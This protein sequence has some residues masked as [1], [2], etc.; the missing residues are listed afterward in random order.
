MKILHITVHP[1]EIHITQLSKNVKKCERNFSA[2]P[3]FSPLFEMN[4]SNIAT[5]SPSGILAVQVRHETLMDRISVY[6]CEH[7]REFDDQSLA[8]FSIGPESNGLM[9]YPS[10]CQLFFLGTCNM[11]KSFGW[12]KLPFWNMEH[13]IVETFC[14]FGHVFFLSLKST[15][16]LSNGYVPLESRWGTPHFGTRHF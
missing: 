14:H 2:S 5:C 16:S 10:K 15:P 12:E 8:L 9:L 1:F 4:T 7:V 6:F 3:N 13:G 11:E